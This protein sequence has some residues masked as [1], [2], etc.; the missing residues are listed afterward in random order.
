M[1]GY[2]FIC[3]GLVALCFLVQAYA[4]NSDLDNPRFIGYFIDAG[5]TSDS[6]KFVSK[7]QMKNVYLIYRSVETMTAP[8]S[9]YTKFT[10]S[11]DY[12]GPCPRSGS[13][14]QVNTMCENGTLSGPDITNV[15]C[16]YR[17][18]RTEY[19]IDN[20]YLLGQSFDRCLYRNAVDF[21]ISRTND[22]HERPPRQKHIGSRHRL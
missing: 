4:N 17:I 8:S 11:G 6:S 7:Q 10:T 1:P 13:N 20:E 21:R 16:E 22:L 18:S 15:A 5:K 19:F 14:C 3:K 9:L 12:A 2:K